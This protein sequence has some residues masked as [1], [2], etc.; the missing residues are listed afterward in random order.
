[1][2][3]ALASGVSACQKKDDPPSVATPPAGVLQPSDLDGNPTPKGL[4]TDEGVTQSCGTTPE[5][6]IH[7]H[8]ES[9]Y[10][11]EYQLD[12]QVKVRSYKYTYGT[13]KSRTK[14]LTGL[15]DGIAICA[16]VQARPGSEQVSA[17]PGLPSAAAGYHIS[18]QLT[19]Y[20]RIGERVWA[21]Q[22]D[23]GIVSI[24]VIYQGPKIDKLPVS[25]ADLAL[26]VAARS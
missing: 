1:V 14:D 22:G 9:R 15:R 3:V 6:Q 2:V 13:E 21:P 7:E 25:A 16:K 24:V 12:D 19:S 17:V 5:M 18:Q 11:V 8:S 10:I 20:Y 4:T 23:K 26:K